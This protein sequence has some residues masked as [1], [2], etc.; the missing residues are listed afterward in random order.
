MQLKGISKSSNL[1]NCHEQNNKI[2]FI[3][4]NSKLKNTLKYEIKYNIDRT[5]NDLLKS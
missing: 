5:I 1:I 3:S 4:N 2:R